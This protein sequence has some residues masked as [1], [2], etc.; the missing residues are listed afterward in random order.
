MTWTIQ[1]DSPLLALAGGSTR[2]ARFEIDAIPP[3]TLPVVERLVAGVAQVDITPPPGLP[4]AGY[5][6][7]AHDG[8]AFRTRLRATVTHLRCGST[9]IAIIQCDLLGGSPVVARLVG[10]AIAETTDIPLAGVW[11]GATHT[12]A[13][14]GQFLGTDFY[15]RFASNRAGFDP[16][17]TQFLAERISGAV[18]EA[19]DT[20][21][22]AQCAIGST[23]VWGLTRNRSM[24]PYVHNT[25]V[26]DERLDP[27][28]KFVSVNPDLH[29]LR[30]DKEHPDGQTTPLG[31]AVIFA[32]H[33]TGVSQ[34]ADEYHGDV[35]SFLTDELAHRVEA[36]HN[37]RPTV[38]AS[39]G[40]HADVAPALRPGQAGFV[41]AGRIGRKIGAAAFRLYGELA[42][43][44]SPQL[45]LGCGLREIDLDDNRVIDG[46]E[47]PD[48]P[49]V[50]ASLLAG[51]TENVTP[52]IHRIPPFA[53]GH[54]RRKPR[55]KQGVKNVVGSRTLQPLV[56]PKRGFPR[57]LT[58]QAIRIGHTAWVGLPFELTTE[59]GRRIADAV[60]EATNGAVPIVCSVVNGYCGYVA[61]PEEYDRQYYE[62]G[63]TL[64][65]PKTQPFL[66]AHASRLASEIFRGAT[67]Q[68]VG[69][70]RRWS[71]ATRQYFQSHQ[72]S[73]HER[74][75]TGTPHFVDPDANHDGYWEASWIDGPPESLAW[76][77]PIMSVQACDGDGPWR[78]ATAHD[79]EVND[80]WWALEI[81]HVGPDAHGGHRYCVRW[82]DPTFAADRK[83]RFVL[84]PNAS[85]GEVVGAAFD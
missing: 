61:T 31:A 80:Q 26:L 8:R 5:S 74:R 63:H 19:Y 11:M 56:L 48:R 46:I 34:H 72:T 9:S 77:E 44:L 2:R 84:A 25:T 52:I 7:N 38:G 13:A 6:S 33:G 79:R 12:H 83:H 14:P 36:T 21:G 45:D 70:T 62:G 41:E 50:G 4:K 16:A 65:G 29:L 27:Q 35:W 54:P 71:L 69:S 28:R 57:I 64:Y 24:E 55:G 51:A 15:N 39:E 85:R 82:W 37:V 60:H 18:Q 40:T 17:W 1:S 58:V 10:R 20:R 30:V 81:R 73:N 49:A 78:P 43:S 67:V 3:R 76:H 22:P 23:P 53:P 66:T 75:F 47:L 32:V 59:T 68:Q 42:R